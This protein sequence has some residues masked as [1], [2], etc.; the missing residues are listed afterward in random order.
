MSEIFPSTTDFLSCRHHPAS[1]GRKQVHQATVDI[2]GQN[3]PPITGVKPTVFG[4]TRRRVVRLDIRG[5]RGI[6]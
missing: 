5:E 2:C 4:V 1:S 6:F 3:T